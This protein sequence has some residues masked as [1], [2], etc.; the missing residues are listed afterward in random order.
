MAAQERYPIPTVGALVQGPSGRILLVR[1]TKWRGTWGVP[2]GKVRWGES[3]EAALRRE[4]REEVGLELTRIRWA[5][6]QEAVND[7]AFYRS[8]HFILLNYFA[9]TDREAVRPNEEIAEWAWVVP[10]SALDYPLNRY[11]RVLIERYLE[12]R[13]G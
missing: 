9:E 3:L 11:T 10:E 6:V 12:E 4:V 13:D 5:L 1:T 7:P 8:A 2:G